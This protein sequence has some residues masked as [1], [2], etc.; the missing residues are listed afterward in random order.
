MRAM[1]EGFLIGPFFLAG[2]VLGCAR[3]RIEGLPVGIV[4]TDRRLVIGAA[5]LF[6]LSAWWSR[7]DR[8]LGDWRRDRAY[9]RSRD[10]PDMKR[11]PDRRLS[12][13]CLD[14]GGSM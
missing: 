3:G 14:D 2:V 5:P 10:E 9:G 11:R 12:W 8:R 1:F 13:R 7:V 6:V 4:I